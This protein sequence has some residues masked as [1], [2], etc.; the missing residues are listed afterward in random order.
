MVNGTNIIR[1]D[2]PENMVLKSEKML[3]KIFL[4]KDENIHPCMFHLNVMVRVGAR[5]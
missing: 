2:F 5:C 1:R 4:C 3:R